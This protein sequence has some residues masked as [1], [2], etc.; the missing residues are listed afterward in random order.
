MT[1][2]VN[3]YV[4]TYISRI[5]DLDQRMQELERRIADL[6]TRVKMLSPKAD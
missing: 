1:Q 2:T 4:S 6:E 3:I 5:N